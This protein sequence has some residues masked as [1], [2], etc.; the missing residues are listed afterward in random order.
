MQITSMFVDIKIKIIENRY[1]K[2][3]IGMED[4]VMITTNRDVYIPH[5]YSM[6]IVG[7]IHNTNMM[8]YY[9]K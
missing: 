6:I 1:Y 7:E 8:N 5:K 2:Y 4:I 9:T 3:N